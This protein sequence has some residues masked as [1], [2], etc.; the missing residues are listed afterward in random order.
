MGFPDISEEIYAQDGSIIW[1]AT[2]LNMQWC[3]I[4]MH[5]FPNCVAAFSSPPSARESAI[6]SVHTVQE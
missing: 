5:L 6:V 4:C 2:G 1:V 3:R